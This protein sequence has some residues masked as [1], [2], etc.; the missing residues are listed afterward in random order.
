MTEPPFDF[1]EVVRIRFK[2]VVRAFALVGLLVVLV[3]LCE[4]IR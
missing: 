3:S 1:N 2:Y 4:A